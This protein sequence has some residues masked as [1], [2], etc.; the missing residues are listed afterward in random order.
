[1]GPFKHEYQDGGSYSVMSIWTD[2][3]FADSP[4]A[5]T[6]IPPT[7]E[8][9]ALL[10]GRTREVGQL[11]SRIASSS[12]HPTIEGDNGIGKTSL[13]SIVSYQ[14]QRDFEM[15]RSQE[16]LYP[17][18]RP[19]QL[20]RQDSL[21]SLT[22][23]VFFNVA[24]AFIEFEPT[25]RRRGYNV[26]DV[27]DVDKWLNSPLFRSGGGGASVATFGVN[28]S[29]GTAPNDGSGFS[30]AGFVHAVSGWLRDC[31]PTRQ[32]GGFICV[33]DNLELLETTQATRALLESMRD[34]LLDLPGLRWVLCGARGIVRSG[35]ASPRLEGRLGEPMDL[36][37][38]G[39]DVVAEVVAQRI[40]HYRV[41]PDAVAPVS[42]EGFRHIYD[43]LN[44]NLRSALKF[45]EDFAFWLHES[46]EE[47]N[48][49]QRN[50]D[51]M[52]SWLTQKSDEYVTAT[53]L[54]PRAWHLFDAIAGLGGSVSPS[55]FSNLGFN[56]SQ[57]MR[58]QV[59]AL[60]DAELVISTIDEQ[61]ARRRT[62]SMTPRGW[63][64]RYARSG[65]RVPSSAP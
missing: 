29:Y 26:P 6:P 12:L 36:A 43:V 57:A 19:F 40:R 9:E 52:E 56:S 47:V 49:S 48:N 54:P 2:F 45:C 28:A 51:L 27:S 63:L 30:D 59:K 5:T 39:D 41:R 61:D 25:L 22:K 7:E 16:A 32:S 60:E 58:P 37:P 55:E 53:R 65:Y 10:I 42:P 21:E 64:V 62:I 1:M 24:Q 20:D 34:S 8:G 46:G 4:Y 13:V 35:A 38:I 50:Q 18:G 17:A 31:F 3:G 11:K 23:R 33:I 44:K 14:L 15:G